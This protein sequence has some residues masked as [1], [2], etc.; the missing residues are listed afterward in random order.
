MRSWLF[1]HVRVCVYVCVYGG[2]VR[3]NVLHLL[4]GPLQRL[5]D[6]R[7]T[8]AQQK[9]DMENSRMSFSSSLAF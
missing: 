1:T 8:A 6:V 4:E 3:D 9:P 7:R 2:G 5:G